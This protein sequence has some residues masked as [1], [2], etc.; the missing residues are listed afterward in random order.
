MNDVVMLGIPAGSVVPN[1]CYT[2]WV[3]AIGQV[4]VRLN[5]YSIAPIAPPMGIFRVA[6]VRF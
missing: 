3:S 2:A 4:T 5:N 1:S 6:A